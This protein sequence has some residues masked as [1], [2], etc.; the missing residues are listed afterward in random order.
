MLNVNDDWSS[1]LTFEWVSIKFKF[2]SLPLCRRGG[3]IVR[4][5]IPIL[6]LRRL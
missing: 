3:R 4:L 1:Y 6:I 2:W 5:W